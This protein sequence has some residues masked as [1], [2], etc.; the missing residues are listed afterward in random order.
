MAEEGGNVIRLTGG[1]KFCE[2][3]GNDI[4]ERM[5]QDNIS[6][7]SKTKPSKNPKFRGTFIRYINC[8]V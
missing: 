3:R 7:D 4:V 2:E 5:G 6:S 1:E 8:K